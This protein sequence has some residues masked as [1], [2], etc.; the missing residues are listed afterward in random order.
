MANGGFFGGLAGGFVAGQGLA[1][2]RQQ[3]Q[4]QQ[5]QQQAQQQQQQF[6]RLISQ[7]EIGINLA[8]NTKLPLAL[9]NQGL[10]MFKQVA[11]VGAEQGLLNFDAEGIGSITLDNI[12]DD[13]FGQAKELFRLQK[14]GP[15]KGGIDFDQLLVGMNELGDGISKNVRESFLGRAEEIRAGRE[16][17]TIAK[18]RAEFRAAP[19]TER[20]DIGERIEALGGEIPKSFSEKQT[21]IKGQSPVG[22]IIADLRGAEKRGDA[23]G[24]DA[25]RKALI[26]SEDG[27]QVKTIVASVGPDGQPSPG[28]LHIW[29]R[30]P[31]G[32]LG[33]YVAPRLSADAKIGSNAAATG[34]RKEFNALK[35]VQNFED[36]QTKFAVMATALEEAQ[37]GIKSF[38]AVDQT[39]ITLF[40]KIT[41]PESVVR[42]SE[43]AR[44]ASDQSLINFIKGKAIK[45]IRGGAG[46]TNTE[47]TALVN[48]AQKFMELNGARF[49]EKKQ[50]YINLADSYGVD[51][52]LVVFEPSDVTRKLAEKRTKKTKQKSGVVRF[53]KSGKRIQ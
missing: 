4:A 33:E 44:T 27:G 25:L 30:Q 46:L 31:N 1:L 23:E 50:N 5:K 39:L 11:S 21:G 35:V 10:E 20:A 7:A 32:Q 47:R 12:G 24:T 26:N 38:V 36:I 34:L 3:F 13:A 9:R 41:D 6:S 43:Y 22:K 15:D 37:R 16:Q 17:E 8:S 53:D 19:P 51:S 29:T 14:L 48:M 18:Q 45:Q 52:N 42:E 40:N 2:Q 49:N 28:E